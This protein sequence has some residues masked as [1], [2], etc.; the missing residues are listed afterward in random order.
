MGRE[1]LS[2][3]ENEKWQT[4]FGA[5]MTE[6]RANLR[7]G[8]EIRDQGRSWPPKFGERTRD[9]IKCMDRLCMKGNGAGNPMERSGIT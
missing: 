7:K 2:V 3:D 8:K 5:G 1:W 4:G 9:R 6:G